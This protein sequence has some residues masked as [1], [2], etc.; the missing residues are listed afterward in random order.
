MT[1]LTARMTARAPLVMEP[2]AS[3]WNETVG[4][5]SWV[6]TMT[7]YIRDKWRH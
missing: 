3:S 7:C 6:P 1:T 2:P 5:C 4:R